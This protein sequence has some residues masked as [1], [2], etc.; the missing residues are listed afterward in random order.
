MVSRDLNMLSAGE[1][2]AAIARGAISSEALVRACLSRIEARENVVHAWSALDADGAIAQARACDAGPRRGPLHGVPFG[3]KDVLAT[4]DL[5][6]QMGSPIYAGFRTKGDAACVGLLRA[7][8]A[9]VLGKTVTCEFAGVAP[10]AT[11]NP[12][13]PARTPG[14]SSSGSA[15]AVADGMVPLAFATQTGGSILRPASFCG[16]VGYKPSYGT[17][18]REGL[19]FAA[20]SLDT[21]GLIARSVEDVALA[22][23]VLVGR[24]PQNVAKATMPP[25][26]GLCR[27]Y[28]WDGKAA[29]ETKACFDEAA[30]RLRRA[31]AKVTEIVLPQHFEQLTPTRE[32]VNDVERA[33]SLAWEWAHRRDLLSPQLQRTI[34]RG[35]GVADSDYRAAL[36]FADRARREL[37][38]LF[39]PFDA[40]LAPCVNGEAPVGLHYAGDP[41]FQGPWTLLHVPTI[42]I[43]AGRGPNG[44]PVGVQLVAPYGADQ[45]LFAVAVW[46]QRVASVQ[47]EPTR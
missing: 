21:I 1:A 36:A 38:T 45:T 17:F 8:G 44:M 18:N 2:A 16:I 29:P 27:T 6:T 34:E 46:L 19:K 11:T 26:I 24:A 3:V 35:L 14:G 7:A 13:D 41:A 32:I 42:T 5:P 4:A 33:R 37:D 23:D 20:E 28:L 10:G 9:I 40:L 15:A 12:F 22:G 25:R 31:G 30:D 43:P 39:Q 47:M